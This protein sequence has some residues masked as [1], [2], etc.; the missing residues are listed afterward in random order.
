MDNIWFASALQIGL[1]LIASAMQAWVA[2]VYAVM[3]ETG[4]NNT[5]IGKIILGACF[6]ND[7]ARS[8]AQSGAIGESATFIHS[9]RRSCSRRLRVVVSIKGFDSPFVRTTTPALP[10]GASTTAARKPGFSPL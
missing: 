10:D 3:V 9:Y 5:E 7:I 2:V 1:A 6:I 8:R 4:F